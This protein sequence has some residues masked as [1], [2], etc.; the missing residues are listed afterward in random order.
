MKW[1]LLGIYGNVFYKLLYFQWKSITESGTTST[2]SSEQ[3]AMSMSHNI[4]R[5]WGL[6]WF[7]IEF[8][9]QDQIPLFQPDDVLIV[10]SAHSIYAKPFG[11]CKVHVYSED[12]TCNIPRVTFYAKKTK[13]NT[14]Q[15]NFLNITNKFD[16]PCTI[17]HMINITH[18]GGTHCR[19]KKMHTKKKIQ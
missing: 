6:V 11:R 12:C 18:D 10:Y 9:F 8:P 4:P 14:T 17:L 2:C 16:I 3:Q 19:K 7:I 13:L 1:Q 15:N 5:H